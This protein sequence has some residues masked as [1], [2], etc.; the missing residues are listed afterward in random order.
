MVK[1]SSELKMKTAKLKTRKAEEAK[2]NKIDRIYNRY[3]DSSTMNYSKGN[4]YWMFMIVSGL[5]SG[6]TIRKHCISMI[7]LQYALFCRLLWCKVGR[8][9]RIFKQY[10]N[11]VNYLYV[12]RCFAL[13]S[14]YPSNSANW[15]C[16]SNMYYMNMHWF[17]GRGPFLRIIMIVKSYA[18]VM[19]TNDA[20]VVLM[21]ILTEVNKH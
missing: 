11:N 12:L 4:S 21:F 16:S 18:H 14:V 8:S 19:P 17:Y 2:R 6:I 15:Q 13:V 7:V 9:S 3:N 1:T 10:E 5:A 20:S